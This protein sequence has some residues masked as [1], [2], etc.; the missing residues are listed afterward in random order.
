MTKPLKYSREMSKMGVVRESDNKEYLEMIDI[1]NKNNLLL[2]LSHDAPLEEVNYVVV[3]SKII[4]IDLMK[5][6]DTSD[7]ST[8]I[9]TVS[10]SD[11]YVYKTYKKDEINE[12]NFYNDLT[13][14][15]IYNIIDIIKIS[16]MQ[17]MSHSDF[18]VFISSLNGGTGTIELKG[19]I[20]KIY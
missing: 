3:A 15:D 9:F 12:N 17:K 1:Y 8:I 2:C 18:I 13:N 6:H 7:D 5:F 11:V 20:R 19:N 16:D 4:I 10:N 14:T